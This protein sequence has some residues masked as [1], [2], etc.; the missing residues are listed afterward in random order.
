[1]TSAVNRR[2]ASVGGP[3]A[4]SPRSRCR[5]TPP[6]DAPRR[7][8]PR[9]DRPAR[10]A[11]AVGRAG[12]A[13]PTTRHQR[14]GDSMRLSPTAAHA[15]R[16]R[17]HP[18]PPRAASGDVDQS[19]PAARG[20]AQ[21]ATTI[22]SGPGIAPATHRSAARPGRDQGHEQAERRSPGRQLSR[23]PATSPG[24]RLGRRPRAEAIVTRRIAAVAAG[25]RHDHGQGDDPREATPPPSRRDPAVRHTTRG[26][27]PMDGPRGPRRRERLA[28]TPAS[29]LQ[30]PDRDALQEVALERDERDDHRDRHDDRAGHQQR[31]VG[32]RRE[33]RGAAADERERHGQRDR[34]PCVSM[35]R[36][37]QMRLFQLPMNVKIP[38]TARPGT[39]AA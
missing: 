21:S 7:P 8:R 6:G 17:Q 1:M 5:R 15:G 20:R 12:R 22:P 38:R 30:R 39:S 31:D 2:G 4:T 9:P 29:S 36:S 32:P 34:G 33:R 35:T 3:A 26:S 37:G 16:A 10:G 13:A 25:R 14:R 18:P 28:R 11:E 24:S 23:R 19:P 27:P